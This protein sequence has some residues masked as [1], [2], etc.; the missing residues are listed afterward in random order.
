MKDGKLISLG[1]D[2][3][4]ECSQKGGTVDFQYL[5]NKKCYIFF[6]LL[7][8]TSSAEENDTKIIKFG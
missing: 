1:P 8:K 3:Y 6:T 5:A 7:D 4:T 2:N